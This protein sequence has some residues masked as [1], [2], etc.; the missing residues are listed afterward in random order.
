[1]S[2]KLHQDRRGLCLCLDRQVSQLNG[3]WF[4]QRAVGRLH[5]SVFVFCEPIF[6]RKKPMEY[7]S[8]KGIVA[9]QLMNGK[10]SINRE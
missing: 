6:A 7:P 10:S 2:L 9:N 1:M 5:L 4:G 3:E 8:L